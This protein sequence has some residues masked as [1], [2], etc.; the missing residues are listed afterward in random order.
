MF[1]RHSACGGYGAPPEPATADGHADWRDRLAG[2]VPLGIA[3]V[4]GIALSLV[5]VLLTALMAGDSNRPEIGY[6]DAGRGSLHPALL[7]TLLVPDVFGATGRAAEYW[8]P[9]ARPGRIR[10]SSSR[11]TWVASISAPPRRC[12]WSAL[13]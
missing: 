4:I 7:L 2:L 6:L 11:R 10:A 12:S 9:Q 3:G 13:A 1:W 5:P 8:G